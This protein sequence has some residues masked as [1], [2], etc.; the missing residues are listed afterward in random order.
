MFSKDIFGLLR[1][2]VQNLPTFMLSWVK[3][4]IESER[5]FFLPVLTSVDMRKIYNRFF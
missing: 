5:D 3:M 4:V 2:Q 1:S